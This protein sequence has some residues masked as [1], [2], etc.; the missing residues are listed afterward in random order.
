MVVAP[1]QEEA[2]LRDLE[3]DK[4]EQK[5]MWQNGRKPKQREKEEK[6]ESENT[7]SRATGCGNTGTVREHRP[8]QHRRTGTV[9]TDFSAH[10]DWTAW[11]DLTGNLGYVMAMLPDVL[12]GIFTGRTP[13]LRIGDNLLPIAS[14]VAGMFVRNPLLKMLLIG[15][16]G[17]NLLNKAGN[18]ALGK[19]RN[20]GKLKCNRPKRCAVPPLCG[21]TVESPYRKSG[22]QGS[23]LIA[24]IDR[25]PCTIQL[26]PTVAE[27]YHAGALPLTLWQMPSLPRAT[28]SGRQPHDTMKT[29][30]RRQSC[31]QG[32][33]NNP[34]HQKKDD[35]KEK[36]QI[37]KKAEEKQIDL[38]SAALGGASNAGGH[39]L[40]ATGKGYP[41]FY[42]KG[43]SVSAFNALFMALH[44]DRNGCKTNLFTLFS[45]AKAQGIS[46]REHEQGVPFLFYNWDRY[47]HRNNPEL[48]ISRGDY[49]KLS[50][51]EQKLYKGVHNREIRTLF[52]IDQTTLPYVDKERYE[53]ALK[54]YGSAVERGYTESDNRQLRIRFNDFLLKMRDN[55]VPVRSDGSGVPHYE[56][57]KD[58]VYMPRQREFDTT[59]TM[60]RKPCGR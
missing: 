34:N 45:D 52:N 21:R 58:A 9:G 28:S 17:A 33:S 15:L 27:A 46:V 51:E 14:I 36:S 25:I 35:M 49:L 32:E 53:A 23:T 3:I 57:D 4:K 2:Y 8:V 20:E 56:T 47:V 12:L 10:W 16:G 41:L 40:N 50:E 38:L 19:E 5:P 24:T 43:V 60:F 55:L 26:S 29:D 48:I 37:E 54:R 11:D 6:K 31:G 59:T 18:E 44:S 42:P 1:G 7:Q 30:S 39:W 22:L 13:S